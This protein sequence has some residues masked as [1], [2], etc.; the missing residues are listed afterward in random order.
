MKIPEL[1][2]HFE[3]ESGEEVIVSGYDQALGFA[4]ACIMNGIPFSCDPDIEERCK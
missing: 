1:V 2:F 4:N 3:I